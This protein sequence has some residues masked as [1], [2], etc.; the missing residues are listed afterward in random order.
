[1]KGPVRGGILGRLGELLRVYMGQ[2]PSSI[3]DGV[4]GKPRVAVVLGAQVLRGGR[5]SRTLEART[6]HAGGL[7]GR[8]LLDL[9]VPTGG[10]GEHPPREAFVMSGI[11]REMGVHEAAILC[12]DTA[13]NT[14]E[15]AVRVAEIARRRDIREV[16]V[17]TDPLHCVRTV[18]SFGRVGLLAVAEP[19]YS[20]PMWR[21]KWSRRGQFVRECGALLWYRIRHGVG[22]S[23]RR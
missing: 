1:L 15:S 20:S 9:L 2:P 3:P 6:R 17:V 21:K 10:E 8:G 18:A 7:Y 16:L 5:P 19:V 11:L 4:D 13:K 23:S 22:L 12:E 14:W